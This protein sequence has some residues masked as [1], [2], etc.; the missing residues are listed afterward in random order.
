MGKASKR[1]LRQETR[2]LLLGSEPVGDIGPVGLHGDIVA[3]IE[4][5]QQR[6]R[7]PQSGAVGHGEKAQRTN[8]RT[9]QEIGRPPAE[10]RRRPVADGADQRLHDEAGHRSRQPQ[11]GHCCLVGTEEFVDRRHVGLLQPEAE[12]QP[13]KADVH[14]HQAPPGYTLLRQRTCL[15]NAVHEGGM[16]WQGGLA[17]HNCKRLHCSN[18]LMRCSTAIVC[19][20]H[21]CASISL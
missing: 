20:L 13:E 17:K 3:S 5:P 2:R 6:C 9:D 19:N 7:D 8:D 10:A 21:F 12:L 11:Q 14:L 1:A 15:R 16:T 18:E 4:Q